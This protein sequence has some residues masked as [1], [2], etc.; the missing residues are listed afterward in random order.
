VSGAKTL[1]IITHIF[2]ILLNKFIVRWKGTHRF[3]L[4]LP[5]FVIRI[6]MDICMKKDLFRY[7]TKNLTT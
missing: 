1:I 6:C 2:Y 4:T 5:G 3:T 7:E